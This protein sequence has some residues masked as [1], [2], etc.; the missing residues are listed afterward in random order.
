MAIIGISGKSGSGKDEIGKIIQYLTCNYSKDHSYAQY[1]DAVKNRNDY[2]EFQKWSIKK[3]ADKL[4]DIVCLLI[5]CTR[6]D[7]ENEEF[8]RTELGEEWRYWQVYSDIRLDKF[9]LIPYKKSDKGFYDRK[10]N[11]KGHVLIKRTPRLL[12]QLLGTDCGREI[13]HP[14]V[15]VNSLMTE[16]KA[17]SVANRPFHKSELFSEDGDDLTWKDVYPN[18]VIADLRFPNEAKAIKDRKGIIIR[19]N[20]GYPPGAYKLPFS[21]VYTGAKG[22]DAFDKIMK[23]QS[24]VKEHISETALDEYDFDYVIDNS[25]SIE[26]LVE[27]VKEVLTAESII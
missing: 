22:M 8:K 25:G 10:S 1:L 16:Y 18:W 17:K 7:L 15:W 21:G 3:F 27:K 14:N 26:E 20:R 12:L 5:G 24:G 19:V 2:P 4:K 11:Y 13:I 6:K 9:E 23:E